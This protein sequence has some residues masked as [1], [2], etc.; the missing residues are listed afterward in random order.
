MLDCIAQFD[1]ALTSLTR[2]ILMKSI[3]SY[4]LILTEAFAF[5]SMLL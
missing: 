5:P 3:L 2:V 4:Q 1:L